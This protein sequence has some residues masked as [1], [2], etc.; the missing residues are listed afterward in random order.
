M[1]IFGGTAHT[2]QIAA[3]TRSAAHNMHHTE[4]EAA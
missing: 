1:P 4:Q 3:A 2:T